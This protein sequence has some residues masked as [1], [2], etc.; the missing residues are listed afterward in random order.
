MDRRTALGQRFMV[1]FDGT[2]VPESLVRLVRRAKLGNVILFRRNIVSASQLCALTKQ[3]TELIEAETGLP[4]FIAIDEEGGS[5][6]RLFQSAAILP[7][8]MA[9]AAT[10]KPE[11]AL[12]AGR[13]TAGQLRRLGVNFDLAPV[14][15]V[16]TNRNN[17][18]IGTRSY[19]DDPE[20]VARFG[21]AMMRGLAEGGA[22]S[23]V[24]HFPGH[25]D[26][27]V[28]SHIGLPLVDKPLD[29]L[30]ASELIPFQAAVDAGAPAVMSAHILFPQLEPHGVPATMSR[31]ILTG[32]LRGQMRF[33]GLILTD[34]M[35]MDAIAKFF[36]TVNGTIEAFAAGADL[37]ILSHDLGLAGRAAEAAE[38]ALSGGTL[39][40]QELMQSCERIASAK[41]GLP[42]VSPSPDSVGSEADR[43]ECLRILREAVTAVTDA[44][45]SLG[46]RPAFLGCPRYPTALVV[47]PDEAALDFAQLAA[48]QLNGTAVSLPRDPSDADIVRALAATAGCTSRTIGLFAARR[49]PGQ[50]LLVAH[51]RVTGIPLCCVALDSPYDLIGL[52]ENVRSLALYGYEA[53]AVALASDALSGRLSPCGALPVRL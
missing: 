6:S 44:P 37:A 35:M 21:A 3:L 7:S 15:D 30:L 53:R 34:C 40:E 31:R 2:E 52:P 11:N 17:P 42:P 36:G 28:D 41:A 38:A 10:G 26:T 18:V 43:A 1:G 29:A 24:K 23:A 12:A 39:S 51:A 49:N 8:A 20:R 50:A 16:N 27:S 32:L 9:V 5:V 19:G 4:P 48:A 25:G 45:F 14:L 47:N 46:E 33:S 22:L 13:I